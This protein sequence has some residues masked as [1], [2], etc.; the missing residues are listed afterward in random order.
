MTKRQIQ[1]ALS[2]LEKR[3]TLA[4][5]EQAKVDRE[6]HALAQK[7]CPFKLGDIVTNESGN[8]F[9][10]RRVDPARSF[11]RY[12]FKLPGYSLVVRKFRR[13]GKLKQSS[14]TLRITD[15]LKLYVPQPPPAKPSAATRR[16]Q[17]L[18]V[19]LKMLSEDAAQKLRAEYDLSPPTQT[20]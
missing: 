19:A 20:Q 5:R 10:V 4:S 17:A 18:D 15:G 7:V 16:K 3:H 9:E 14:E 12:S 13:D 8:R 6:L 2:K 1:S 11:W